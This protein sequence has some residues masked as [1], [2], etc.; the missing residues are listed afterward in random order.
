MMLDLI[1]TETLAEEFGRLVREYREPDTD[2]TQA[3]AWNL[4]ADFAVENADVI[5]RALST[6][7]PAYFG[8]L[9]GV[10]EIA[11]AYETAVSQGEAG[12]PAAAFRAGYRAALAE[13]RK[14]LEEDQA[15]TQSTWGQWERAQQEK[16]RAGK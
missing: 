13:A 16:E 2:G 8:R 12:Y 6:V 1:Q 5:T 11:Q 9:V 4:I 7:T 3:E 14:A 10:Q 15:A